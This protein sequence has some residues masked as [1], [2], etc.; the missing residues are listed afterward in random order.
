MLEMQHV[1]LC[2]WAVRWLTARP[3][4]ISSTWRD[5]DTVQR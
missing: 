3:E 1:G 4:V 5:S 2:M